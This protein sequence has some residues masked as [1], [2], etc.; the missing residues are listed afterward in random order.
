MMDK[1]WEVEE[2]RR[3]INSEDSRMEEKGRLLICAEMKK[4]W[5]SKDSECSHSKIQEREF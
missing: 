2:E 3:K 4:K 1:D 5:A